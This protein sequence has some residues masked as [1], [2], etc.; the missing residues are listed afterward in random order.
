VAQALYGTHGDLTALAKILAGG[1]P[2]GAV[3]GRADVLRSLDN[4]PVERR[5]MPKV[6]H[7]GTFNANPLSSAAGVA[8]LSLVADPAVQERAT[9]TAARIRAGLNGALRAAGVPGSVYGAASLF[10]VDIGGEELP[11]ASDLT[12]PLPGRAPGHDIRPA[13]VAQALNLGML[14]RGIALFGNWG[15]TSI[16]HS[17]DDAQQT[18]EAFAQ[19]LSQLQTNGL[20]RA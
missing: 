19:T 2:G 17:D 18:V 16:A 5:G 11:P 10:L 7:P 15:I 6:A 20:L 14:S 13:E 1:L 3:V 8:C 4:R 9:A 12:G